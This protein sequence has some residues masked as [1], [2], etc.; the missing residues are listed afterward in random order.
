MQSEALFAQLNRHKK[1]LTANRASAAVV[2]VADWSPP[3]VSL[4][5]NIVEGRLA[6]KKVEKEEEERELKNKGDDEQ[7]HRR[8]FRYTY[9]W[10]PHWNVFILF[11]VPE[12]RFF[13]NTCPTS[14]LGKCCLE[15]LICVNCLKTTWAV[16][17]SGIF[18]F[19]SASVWSLATDHWPVFFDLWAALSNF[20]LKIRKAK[21][22]KQ[23]SQ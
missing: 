8:L 16:E 18:S 2:S 7:G 12:L 9:R 10:S 13:A 3:A 15:E 14:N 19:P 21:S 17:A 1:Q 11:W 5:Q 23:N 22:A 20:C 6:E 4:D